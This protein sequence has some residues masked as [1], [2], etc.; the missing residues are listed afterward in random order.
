[1]ITKFRFYD[2]R[3]F[4]RILKTECY[5]GISRIQH[6]T[7]HKIKFT[8]FDSRSLIFG[9]QTCQCRKI[10]FTLCHTVCIITQTSL[11]I[12]N[13]SNRNFRLQCNNLHLYLSRNIRDTVLRKILEIAAYFCRSYLDISYQF[14]LHL[15]YCQSV[16]GIFA[17]R[18]TNLSSSLIEVFLH[19]LLRTNLLDIHIGHHIYTLNDFRFGNFDTI[20]LC[21]VQ[22]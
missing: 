20:Q 19:F 16:T 2:L 11:Y 21:L 14:L 15:L 22:E 5:I 10:N 17:Q 18:F 7:S 6:T 9:I 8:T 12:F 3:N 1:M 4:L 13:F